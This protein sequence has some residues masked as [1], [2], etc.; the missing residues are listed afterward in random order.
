[1]NTQ[2]HTVE[3]LLAVLEKV[4]VTMRRDR[5]LR[6]DLSHEDTIGRSILQLVTSTLAKQ[7]NL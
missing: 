4:A 7:R 5:L 2:D 1:M 6:Q 3:A